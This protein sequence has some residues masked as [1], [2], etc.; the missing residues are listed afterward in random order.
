MNT[1]LVCVKSTIHIIINYKLLMIND[2][3][4]NFILTWTERIFMFYL[5]IHKSLYLTYSYFVTTY[6]KQ[7]KLKYM[8]RVEDNSF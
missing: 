8:L 5:F 1:Y 6:H 3:S 4:Q 2:L 7:L